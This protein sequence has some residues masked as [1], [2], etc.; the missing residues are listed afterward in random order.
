ADIVTPNRFEVAF[1]AGRDPEHL[2]DNAALADAARSLGR[3]EVVVTSAFAGEG[4]TANLLVTRD[5]SGL[6]IHRAF[7]HAPHGTGDILAALYLGHRLDGD[8]PVEALTRAAGATVR[9]VE[10]AGDADE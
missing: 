8:D 10:L 4:E 3:P 5:Y 2:A 9:L 6:V 7:A 1:L